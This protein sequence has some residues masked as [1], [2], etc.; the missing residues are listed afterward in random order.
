MLSY[1]FLILVM[2]VYALPIIVMDALSLRMLC[3]FYCSLYFLYDCDW[4]PKL[5][6][7]FHHISTVVYE[8]YVFHVCPILSYACLIMF[9]VK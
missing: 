6:Y 1:D 8:F 3:L 4:F 2:V 9:I 7:D 5:S